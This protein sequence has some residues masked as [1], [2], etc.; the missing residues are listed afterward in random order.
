ML[1]EN[2]QLFIIRIIHPGNDILPVARFR[3]R[4]A[5][6]CPFSGDT[7]LSASSVYCSVQV[8]ILLVW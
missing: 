8:A 2:A 7:F 1:D 5:V 3:F 6:L 4:Q